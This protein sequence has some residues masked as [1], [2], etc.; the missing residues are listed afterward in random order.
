[1][2][3]NYSTESGFILEKNTPPQKKTK[4]KKRKKHPVIGGF[5]LNKNCFNQY[6]Q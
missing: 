3:L 2:G 6:I 1:M 4:T 5:K